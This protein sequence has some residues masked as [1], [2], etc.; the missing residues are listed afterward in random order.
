MAKDHPICPVHVIIKYFQYTTEVDPEG[1]AFM[2]HDKSDK[3]VPLNS[4]DYIDHIKSRLGSDDNNYTVYSF[5]KD[6]ASWALIKMLGDWISS[7]GLP[8]LCQFRYYI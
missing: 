6:G 3:P 2:T 8:L 7:R 4:R 5:R 1:P